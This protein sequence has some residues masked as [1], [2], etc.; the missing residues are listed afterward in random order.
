[1][2]KWCWQDHAST[3]TH[4]GK[5]RRF[6]EASQPDLRNTTFADGM[7]AASNSARQ[8]F[9]QPLQPAWEGATAHSVQHRIPAGAESHG[10]VD[11]SLAFSENLETLRVWFKKHK[12]GTYPLKHEGARGKLQAEHSLAWWVYNQRTLYKAD[13]LT[14]AQ[15]QQ[16]ESIAEWSWDPHTSAWG[17]SYKKVKTWIETHKKYPSKISDEP[18]EQQLGEWVYKQ[19]RAYSG[20][21][22]PLL[23][24]SRIQQQI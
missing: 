10:G 3:K 15:V 11:E 18:S 1:M 4:R 23:I 6:Q 24:E 7:Q 16:L 5:V 14:V 2:I 20:S 17:E 9:K 8:P 12:D 21:R 22:K 19:M 13:K